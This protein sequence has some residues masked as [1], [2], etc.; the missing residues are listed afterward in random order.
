MYIAQR[1]NFFLGLTG[2]L[3]LLAISAIV[4]FGLT[5]GIEFTG[6]TSI[7]VA[8]ENEVT[9]KETIEDAVRTGLG[10]TSFSVQEL[11][12]S[13]YLIK[14][15]FLEENMRAFVVDSLEELEGVSVTELSSVGPTIG[16]ELQQKSLI[17]VLI[18]VMS[19]VLFVAFAFRHVSKPVSPWL[20]GAAT[21]AAL[22]FDVLI[23]VGA[24]AIWGVL[25]GAEVDSLFII[26]LLTVLGYSV[27]DTIIV[28]DRIREK[29]GDAVA[30]KRK[31]TFEETV[32]KSIDES[33]TRSINTSLTTA[34]ALLALYILGGEPTQIFALTLLVGV[35]SGT[36][37]SI[38]FASPLLLL[39]GEIGSKKKQ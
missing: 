26:A 15:S 35:L 16:S 23:A 11:G 38:F 34:L 28:F 1:K 22:V 12:E 27:N 6:G 2:V 37:S 24:F 4:F 19:I 3:A 20:F 36:Y 25:F 31:D 13:G 5:S 7:G 33:L 18:V 30:K 39:F 17:A 9:I 21:I 32:G 14:T 8:V 10:Q 29:L